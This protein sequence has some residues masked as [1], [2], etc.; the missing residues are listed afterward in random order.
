MYANQGLL[1]MTIPESGLQNP[2]SIA[3]LVLHSMH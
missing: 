2:P 3:K 1:M